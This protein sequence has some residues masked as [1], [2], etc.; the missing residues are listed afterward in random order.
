LLLRINNQK[1]KLN[2]CDTLLFNT[3]YNSLIGNNNIDLNK[4]LGKELIR[5][6]TPTTS[7]TRNRYKFKKVKF[8]DDENEMV[9]RRKNYSTE[10]RA[11]RL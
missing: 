4:L 9:K 8:A 10:P 7:V 6:S 1:G 2:S 11:V 3:Y 5:F